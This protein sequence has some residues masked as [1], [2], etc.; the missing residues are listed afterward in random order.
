MTSSQFGQFSPGQPRGGSP[1]V[2]YRVTDGG[3]GK[4]LLVTYRVTSTAGV[5]EY[6]WSQDTEDDTTINHITGNFSG[7]MDQGTVLGPSIMRATGTA[8]FDRFGQAFAG[9]ADDQYRLSSGAY[10]LVASGI[11]GSGITGCHQRG[12]KT[13][14]IPADQGSLHVNGT[15]PDLTAPYSYG[16]QINRS[17]ARRSA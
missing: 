11:D 1:T 5:A 16:F 15:P 13:F 17:A 6:T 8:T 3:P 12:S 4:L 2:S 9:G 14:Q 7:E 10:T